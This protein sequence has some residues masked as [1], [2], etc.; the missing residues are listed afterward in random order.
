[1]HRWNAAGGFAC[2]KFILIAAALVVCAQAST[3][4][5]ETAV[6]ILSTDPVSPAKFGEWADLALRVGYDSSQS[7]I[8]SAEPLYQGQPIPA[9]TG[10]EAHVAAGQGEILLWF[11]YTRPQRIDAVTVIARSIN[12]KFL[13]QT[14]LPVELAW[15]GRPAAPRARAEWV[16]RLKTEQQNRARI[17]TEALSRTPLTQIMDLVAEA[18]MLAVPGYFLLQIVLLWRLSGGWR[19]AAAAPLLPMGAVVVYTVYALADGS[20]IAPI[21]L[22]FT[23]PLSFIYLAIIA[24]LSLM[25]NGPALSA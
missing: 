16:Q 4:R 13:T 11:A 15:S 6:R 19:K 5:A 25:R 3:V 21:V 17:E 2:L 12:G 7:V 9:M 20:N 22:A 8:I 24:W 14:N 1:M 10:G 18:M 23:A